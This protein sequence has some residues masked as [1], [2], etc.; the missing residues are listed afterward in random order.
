MC[1]LYFAYKVHPKY[2]LILAANRDEFYERPTAPIHFWEDHPDI[3]AGRDL[4]E[5]G[6]WMGVNTQGRIAALTNFR[7]PNEWTNHKISR[8]KI[9]REF[10]NS[11]IDPFTFLKQLQSTRS[12]YRGFNIIVGTTQGLYYY[13]NVQNE[14]TEIVPGIHGLSNHFLNTT[15]P[16]VEKGKHDMSLCIAKESPIDH[17]C[18]FEILANR[19]RPEIQHLP[20]TGIGLE[21][22]EKLSSIFIDTN[23]YGTR[24]SSVLTMSSEDHVDFVEK[25]IIDGKVNNT[26]F[27]FSIK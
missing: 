7:D 24:S 17:E 12:D 3:L 8:G 16:K 15:W 14:I 21:W 6:T 27:S 2:P 10:L 19:D 26:H 23:T 13:S 5:K 9:V 18:L 4:R 1:V 11:E 25:S 22:E 20:N